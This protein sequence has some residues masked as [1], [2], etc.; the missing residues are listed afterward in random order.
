MRT[1]VVPGDVVAYRRFASYLDA[2]PDI[3]GEV[4]APDLRVPGAADLRRRV[5]ELIGPHLT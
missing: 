4:L 3:V 5:A 2:R 1:G